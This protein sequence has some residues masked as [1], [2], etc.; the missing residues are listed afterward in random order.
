MNITY[1]LRQKEDNINVFNS[2]IHAL[3]IT[4]L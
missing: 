2:T 3:L 4:H 1:F